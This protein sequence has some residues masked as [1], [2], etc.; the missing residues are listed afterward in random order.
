M[1]IL[2]M[3]IPFTGARQKAMQMVS[4][5]REG[6]FPLI[7]REPF[8]GA[9]Q[10]NLEVSNRLVVTFHAVFNCMTL[11]ASDIS[12]LRVKLVQQVGGIWTEV[13]NPAYSPVLRKPNAYQNRIQ[14]IASWVL[15]KLMTGNTYVLKV[16]DGRNVVVAMHI[17]DPNRCLP[18][19]AD[20]GSVFYQLSC[21]RLAGFEEDII[22]PAREIIHD[23]WNCLFHPLVGLSPI[24]ACGLAATQGLNI[25]KNSALLFAN[26]SR[27]SGLLVAPGS[28]DDD[29]AARMKSK[30]EENYGGNNV[31]R[32]AVL[33]NGLKFEAMTMNAVDAQMV[34]QLKWSAATCCSTFHMPLYKVGLGDLPADTSIQALNLEYYSECLQALIESAELCLDEGLEMASD[35]GTEFDTDGLLRMDSVAQMEVLDKSKGILS[36]NEQRMKLNFGPVPGGGSPY[37]QQQ[38]FSLEALAKRDAQ[39]DPFKKDV[40]TQPA[41]DARAPSSGEDPAKRFFAA[42]T[43]K[44]LEALHHA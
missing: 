40:G 21:D 13:T 5:G 35:M 31:G 15:S 19:V 17:L 25:Q 27:P 6:W 22:V 26:N 37:L 28:V 12:K 8:A 20:D 23:R 41:P 44:F 36:P 18:L 7:V 4:G 9:W 34:E 16:R 11:I 39:D 3:P 2:G 29:T 38:N 10:K 1:K 42:A 14:F 33:G 24:I 32:V 43:S 30:W